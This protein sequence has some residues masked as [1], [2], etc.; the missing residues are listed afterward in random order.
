MG[1]ELTKVYSDNN[2]TKAVH[3]F[4]KQNH[5]LLPQISQPKIYLT[6]QNLMGRTLVFGNLD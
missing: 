6:L 4:F 3:Q 2:I 1:P 5:S